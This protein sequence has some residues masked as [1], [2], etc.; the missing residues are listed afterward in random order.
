MN[1]IQAAMI[2]RLAGIDEEGTIPQ[3]LKDRILSVEQ[4]MRGTG[5]T[6]LDVASLAI[7]IDF[8]LRPQGVNSLSQIA[9]GTPVLVETET[10][11]ED[12][13]LVRYPG[14]KAAGKVHV[15]MKDQ[16][17]GKWK[18]VDVAKVSLPEEVAV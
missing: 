5:I 18:V 2:R 11:L 15:R 1:N 7:L 17:H 3:D 8:F 9:S 4:R 10:G 16:A 6:R 13:T 14:G 12:G